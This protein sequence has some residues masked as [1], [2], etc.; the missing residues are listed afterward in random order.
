MDRE[1]RKLLLTHLPLVAYGVVVAIFAIEIPVA[2]SPPRT[3]ALD[4][5]E[6]LALSIIGTVQT[7]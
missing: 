6:K 7:S 1:A 2:G 4:E 3:I 5:V